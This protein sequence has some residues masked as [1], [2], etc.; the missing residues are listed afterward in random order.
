MKMM[1]KLT[2]LI[3]AGVLMA[4]ALTGCSASLFGGSMGEKYV[5]AYI[6]YVNDIRSKDAV[7][8][9]NDEK[10]AAM[11]AALLEKID[12]NGEVDDNDL[13]WESEDEEGYIVIEMELDETVGDYFGR[14]SSARPITAE[15]INEWKSKKAEMMATAPG[16]LDKLTKR[17]DKYIAIGAAYRTIGDNIYGAYGYKTTD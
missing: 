12:E 10:I 6:D 3:L 7:K 2:A 16:Q 8:L 15:V 9:K 13:F 4:V 5:E 14:V 17:Y 1:K 11:C